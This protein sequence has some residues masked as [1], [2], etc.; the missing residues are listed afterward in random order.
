[1]HGTSTNWEVRYLQ[2]M[3]TYTADP[4]NSKLSLAAL[5]AMKPAGVLE[6]NFR[7]VLTSTE[8]ITVRLPVTDFIPHKAMEGFTVMGQFQPEGQI[9][10]QLN[11]TATGWVDFRELVAAQDIDILDD[12]GELALEALLRVMDQHKSGKTPLGAS[13][14][15]MAAVADNGLSLELQLQ[16][17]LYNPVN[18]GVSPILRQAN[19]AT[20]VLAKFG[21]QAVSFNGKECAGPIP[22]MF[23]SDPEE[24]AEL[25]TDPA[26]VHEYCQAGFVS[27]QGWGGGEVKQ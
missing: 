7:L 22:V 21:I 16:A 10:M 2:D 1:M 13:W 25:L 18:L 20:I 8:D 15:W 26:T 9:V 3:E 24:A 23:S 11:S 5:L 14:R 4:G 19:V 6:G 12:K 17:L 27:L